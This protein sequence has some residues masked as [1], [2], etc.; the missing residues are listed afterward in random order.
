MIYYFGDPHWEHANVIKHDGRPFQN[1]DEMN[2][3]LLL[4]YNNRVNN[5]DTVVLGGDIFFRN[6]TN[7]EYY[8][9]QLKGSKILAIGNHDKHWLKDTSLYKYFDEIRDIIYIKDGE[10]NV[11]VSHYPMVEWDGYFRGYYHVYNHI[12]NNTNDTYYIMKQRE[13]ALNGGCMINNYMPVTFK[14]LIKNNEIFKS[15]H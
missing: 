1:I 3:T 11:I 14:E 6:K 2:K 8:L 4:N 5:N 13:R 12:H 15:E 7:P 9:K 10:H